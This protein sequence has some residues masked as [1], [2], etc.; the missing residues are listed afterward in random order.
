VGNPWWGIR[1]GFIDYKIFCLYKM[2]YCFA[3]IGL[4]ILVILLL[5]IV[6]YF[7][8]KKFIKRFS[9]GTWIDSDGNVLILKA[10]KKI[11]LSFGI[12]KDDGTYELAENEY[13][14]SINKKWFSSE[15]VIIVKNGMTI[16]IDPV[17]GIATV[18]DKKKKVG[19]FAKNN[20]L[21]L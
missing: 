18:Y 6:T 21:L 4:V 7:A 16:T 20:L 3:A 13:A 9:N 17:T 8:H 1:G 10:D 5:M 19:R 12:S 15:Y 11:K 2:V 14:Y